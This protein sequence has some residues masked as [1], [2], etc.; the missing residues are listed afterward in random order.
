MNDPVYY[1]NIE[2]SEGKKIA[3]VGRHEICQGGPQ[4]GKLSIDGEICFSDRSFGGP[5]LEVN[6][7]L[8]R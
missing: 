5:M 3:V 7:I 2:S 6:N 4:V 8:S 1:D